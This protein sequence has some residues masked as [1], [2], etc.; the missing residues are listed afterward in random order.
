MAC[1]WSL[2]RTFAHLT[3][4][5]ALLNTYVRVLNTVAGSALEFA[6]AVDTVELTAEQF[7][8]R[9]AAEFEFHSAVQTPSFFVART[10]IRS[11]SAI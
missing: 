4:T 2:T 6:F 8:I 11:M 1:G 10:P 7:R 9:D 5:F 3:R